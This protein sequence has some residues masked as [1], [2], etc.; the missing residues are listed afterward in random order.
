MIKTQERR[1][2]TKPWEPDKNGLLLVVSGP[3]AVGKD[4][5]LDAL[6]SLP[7]EILPATTQKCVTT[8]TREPRL[9]ETDG[10]DY[11]FVSAA[12]FNELVARD[13][14]LEYAEVHNFYYGTPRAAV[15]ATRAE[16][17]DVILKIDVQGG[18]AVK[19]KMP[20]AVLIFLQ[21]PSLEELERRLRG[22]ATENEEDIARRLLNA[23][24]EMAQ[25]PYYDYAVTNDAVE[26]AVD[27][28]VA[29]LR[30]EHC[31]IRAEKPDA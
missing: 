6:L 30:A 19:Q 7:G 5:V 28:I 24:R 11:T 14:F 10:V 17:V 2:E 8:T 9:L 4:T 25:R 1:I 26:D 29:I 18:R 12:Q 20:D 13:E 3:S 22:R 15:A 21:P 23:R 31:R 16:G 27:T